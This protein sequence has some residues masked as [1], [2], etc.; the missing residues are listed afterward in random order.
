MTGTKAAT[1]RSDDGLERDLGLGRGRSTTSRY[2]ALVHQEALVGGND[3]RPE[4]PGRAGEGARDWGR[5]GLE[6]GAFPSSS[7]AM[8]RRDDQEAWRVRAETGDGEGGKGKRGETCGDEL[9]SGEWSGIV[10]IKGC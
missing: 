9:K 4:L 5:A 3:A 2:E 7:S 1:A 8:G 6:R 10:G